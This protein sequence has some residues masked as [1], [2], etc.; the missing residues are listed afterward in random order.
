MARPC[1]ARAAPSSSPAAVRSATASTRSSSTSAA[2]GVAGQQAGPLSADPADQVGVAG[3][4]AIAC[5]VGRRPRPRRRRAARRRSPPVMLAWAT[6][7]S[8]RP[9]P[10]DRARPSA[11]AARASSIRPS[12]PGTG[13]ARPRCAAGARGSRLDV[14]VLASPV[15]RG[16]RLVGPA[17]VAVGH[18]QASQRARSSGPA[19]GMRQQVRW[20][21]PR[22]CQALV[23]PARRA[24]DPADPASGSLPAYLVARPRANSSTA[25]AR[26]SPPR[27]I[28]PASA[29]SD[30]VPVGPAAALQRRSA[31]PGVPLVEAR[32]R[33]RR[34]L[35][36]PAAQVILGR[37][38]S[39]SGLG[40]SRHRVPASRLTD[41]PALVGDRWRRPGRA[42]VGDSGRCS[43][44]GSAS[45]SHGSGRLWWSVPLRASNRAAMASANRLSSAAE[46]RRPAVGRRPLPVRRSTQ[47]RRR[48]RPREPGAAPAPPAAANHIAAQR[49]RRLVEP[50]EVPLEDLHPAR[51]VAGQ[52]AELDVVGDVAQVGQVGPVQPVGPAVRVAG[53]VQPAGAQ[54]RL[55]QGGQDALRLLG[56]GQPAGQH[57]LGQRDRLLVAAL[58]GQPGRPSTDG[59]QPTQSDRSSRGAVHH[60]SYHSSAAA[61]SPRCAGHVVPVRVDGVQAV[62]AVAPAALHVVQHARRS[63]PAA[64]RGTWSAPLTMYLKCHSSGVLAAA[65]TAPGP[66]RTRPGT[67][68]T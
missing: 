37:S 36:R 59:S 42:A 21:P 16:Q 51:L 57:R 1:R 18:G 9:S 50:A 58:A 53:L 55:E 11:A 14:D 27:L 39:S 67:R 6:P 52:R 3:S 13:P 26:Q 7:S 23:A 38:S 66:G 47:H 44:S 29:A 25:T 5:V 24:H 43:T 40:G 62:A 10:A 49:R 22:P 41:R 30:A 61:R 17:D 48:A 12:E 28:A 46:H 65:R 20:R 31:P 4:T 19:T 60:R 35:G 64:P 32:A 56:A 54:V 2:R 63:G 68:R 34:P 15:Q 45:S 8:K 33:R